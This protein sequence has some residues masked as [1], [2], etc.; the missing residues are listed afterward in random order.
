MNSTE[1]IITDAEEYFTNEAFKVLRTNIQFCGQDIKVIAI[2]SCGM[3]EGKTY[4]SLHLGRSLAEIGK[5]VLILDT[6][7]RKSVMAERDSSAEQPKGLSEVLTGQAK[8]A[9]CIY[10][11]QIENLFVLFSGTYPPNPV[12]LLNTSHFA[13]LMENLQDVYDYIIVDTPPLGLVIDAAVIATHC[14][15]S[16]LVIGNNRTKYMEANEAIEQFRKVGCNVLGAILNNV[17]A[18]GKSYYK[19]RKNYGYYK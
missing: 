6:D 4:V 18:K 7:M 13:L 17:N 2:T 1:L 5:R 8:L 12:E 9:D 14:D 11:T 15:S 3:N 19:Y 16:I 10:S